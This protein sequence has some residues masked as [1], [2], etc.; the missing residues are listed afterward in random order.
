MIQFWWKSDNY[1]WW[2]G[3]ALISSSYWKSMLKKIARKQS[4][5]L[6]WFLFGF[7]LLHTVDDQ[8]NQ[9]R[10]LSGHELDIIQFIYLWAEMREQHWPN[11]HLSD[12]IRISIST[13]FVWLGRF[14]LQSYTRNERYRKK[15]WAIFVVQFWNVTWNISLDICFNIGLFGHV[16][17]NSIL[18][19]S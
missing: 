5:K 16:Q 11:D 7:L 19:R 17:G 10:Y 9:A 18:M 3:S 14:L 6:K 15:F 4:P 1:S 2:D 8:N 13:H 12:Q